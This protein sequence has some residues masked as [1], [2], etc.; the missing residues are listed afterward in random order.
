MSGLLT[1]R[2]F[3]LWFFCM[4]VALWSLRFLIAGVETSM[5]FVAYHAIERKLAF[6]AH[7]GL[8]PVALALLPLQF[9]KG[10]RMRRPALHRWL[11]RIYAM[12]ILC[13]GVGSILMA[14]GT[15]AGPVASVGFLL[16]GVAWITSTA[17]AVWHIR[18]RR[19]SEHRAWM[20]RSAALTF[21]AVTL[22]LEMPI[23]AMTVGLDVGYPM[24]AWL[25]WV[26]NILIAEWMLPRD[27][28]MS[29]PLAAQ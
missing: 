7:V 10:L 11:G 16:L 27:G 13:A 17:L 28:R 24:V 20:I 3:F 12:A 8:A 4:A 25:C 14:L 19:V 22:R 29:R 26:P 9:W 15:K 18:N 1:V 21:A 23:L 2:T 5:A 6:F